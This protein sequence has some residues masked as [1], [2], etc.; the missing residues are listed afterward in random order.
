MLAVAAWC[1]TGC[2]GMPTRMAERD[3]HQASA[4]GV[5]VVTDGGLKGAERV[6][7]SL[8]R[9]R[10][11]LLTRTSVSPA[12]GAKP[13]QILLVDGNGEYRALG[14][15]R[16]RPSL[17]ES[18]LRGSFVL[19]T[20]SK[21]RCDHSTNTHIK[22]SSEPRTDNA[23]QASLFRAYVRHAFAVARPNEPDWYVDGLAS[24]LETV[25][26]DA[27]GG[28]TIG[29]VDEATSDRMRIMKWISIKRI[30]TG[31]SIEQVERRDRLRAGKKVDAPHDGP[32]SAHV[33]V[34]W[35]RGRTTDAYDQVRS[36][37]HYFTEN[38]SRQAQL[39]HFLKLQ[40][41]NTPYEAAIEQAFHRSHSELDE[42]LEQYGRRGVFRC[43]R[44]KNGGAVR[45]VR[46]TS[47]KRAKVVE[48]MGEFMLATMGPDDALFELMQAQEEL[49]GLSRRG[50]AT[51]ARAHLAR[52]EAQLDA[53]QGS[54]EGHASI[55]ADLSR[56]EARL[57]A[58]RA[59]RNA[60]WSLPDLDV[61]EG[62][63]VLLQASAGQVT[64]KEAVDAARAAFRRAIRE[65]PRFGD[66][67]YQFGRS[68]LTHDDGSKAPIN[69]L[70]AAWALAPKEPAIPLSLATLLR[71]RGEDT[72]AAT[73]LRRGLRTTAAGPERLEMAALLRRLTRTRTR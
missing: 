1:V 57:S 60:E 35:Q 44:V 21:A 51:L 3:W 64:P 52:A 30:M 31:E 28:Y 58:A 56:A 27:D 73:V 22:C 14:G 6:A 38:R 18:T 25:R 69:A 41:G 67:L 2:I 29:C 54:P 45:A 63:L 53:Q 50:L 20:Q 23:V 32:G 66:A 9:F 47:L 55:V 62:K 12:F 68:Y 40:R 15:S 33:Q 24:Y 34:A 19:A 26:F 43:L 61:I 46:G 48:V 59:V 70:K 39:D 11:V 72:E 13:L 36:M 5:R 8:V 71:K 42:I 7:L 37:I 49:E 4:G 16:L 10:H 65:D 17:F